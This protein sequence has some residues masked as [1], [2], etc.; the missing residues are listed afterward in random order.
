MP[1]RQPRDEL[2]NVCGRRSADAEKNVLERGGTHP[3]RKR[4]TRVTQP[5]EILAHASGSSRFKVCTFKEATGIQIS[6]DNISADHYFMQAINRQHCEALCKMRPRMKTCTSYAFDTT[7]GFF[8]HNNCILMARNVQ[9][10]TTFDA[11]PYQLYENECF[12]YE[13]NRLQS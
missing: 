2:L 5:F 12:L 13:F 3:F 6:S 7:S 4:V 9:A 10:E 1:K 8:N 11:G